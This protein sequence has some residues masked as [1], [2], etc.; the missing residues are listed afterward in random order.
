MQ[1]EVDY[2]HRLAAARKAVADACVVCRSV[3]RDLEQIRAVTKDDRSPV[4]VADWASQ[5]VIVRRLREELGHVNMVAE[6]KA[7]ALRQATNAT[8]LERVL[9][10]VRLVWPDATADDVLDAIDHGHDMPEGKSSEA[11]GAIF[12]TL[13]P[14]DGTKGFMRGEQ[15]AISLAW[16]EAGESVLGILGC[17]NLSADF[18]H[19]FDQPDA[20]G[21]VYF[22]YK[23]TGVWEAPAD[24]PDAAPLHIRRLEPADGEPIRV[25]ESVETGHSKQDDTA[26]ILEI[27]GATE[28][29]SRLDSQAKYAVVARG[30]ADA[31]LRMPTRKGYVERIWDH[32]AGAI[33]ASEAG[34]AV[35]DIAGRSLDFGRGRGLEGNRGIVCA[36]ARP[37]GKIIGAIRDLGLDAEPTE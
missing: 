14:I 36:P 5:A 4:T 27:V 2:D 26:R 10:A 19:P 35:T 12:W 29:P 31:Y 3:Q 37:H 20:H 24:D 9:E 25:C 7:D 30:Q 15:Y 23:G 18:S 32:A 6:E 34:C 21:C 1:H 11:P 13:D 17:P 33:I 16:I 28:E 22:A 8:Q